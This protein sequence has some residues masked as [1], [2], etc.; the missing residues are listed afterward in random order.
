MKLLFFLLLFPASVYSQKVEDITL[1]VVYDVEYISKG[2]KVIYDSCLLTVSPSYSFFYSL[3]K[4]RSYQDAEKEFLSTNKISGNYNCINCFPYVFYKSYLEKKV[5]RI[6]QLMG[7]SYAYNPPTGV[8]VN[9]DLQNDTMLI[10]NIL[11]LKAIGKCDS[12][13]YE[14]YY[15]PSISVSD[16]P[17]ILQGL[18]GLILKSQ[19][20]AGLKIELNRIEFS[21]NQKRVN[22]YNSDFQFTTYKQF[23]EVEDNL[24]NEINSGR[25]IS[26]PNGTTIQ[27]KSN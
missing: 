7:E 6:Q 23:K 24:K 26:L 3:G 17:S 19:S 5:Y 8:L 21:D 15:A 9:W 2:K 14:V 11:C 13:I 4:K 12:T 27:R 22:K 20:S 16:G 25:V 18:P 10:N 1:S